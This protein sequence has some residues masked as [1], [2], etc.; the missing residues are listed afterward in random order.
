[1]SSCELVCCLAPLA[2]CTLL[3]ELWM[4]SCKLVSS[5]E[6]LAA[7]AVLKK[8]A[9]CRCNTVLSVAPLQAC[10]LL[11]VLSLGDERDSDPPGLAAIKAA[12]PRL[13]ISHW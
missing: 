9:V 13:R 11:E 1:M 7:C 10:A 6:P 3:E 4:S 8:V 12:L 2:A 5:L